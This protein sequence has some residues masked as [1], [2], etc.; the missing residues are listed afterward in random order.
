[1]DQIQNNWKRKT[2]LFLASQCITLF[3]SMIV[4]MSII[5]Y[6]TL[7]TSS[8]GWVAAFTICS[9]LP[10]FLISFFAGVWADRY[11]RK[12]LIVLADGVITIATLIMFLVMPMI[13]SDFVLL[14]ALLVISIVRSIGAGVQT[15]AV[16]AVIPHLVPAEYLMKYNG[17][18]ATIQ[19]IVQFI[20]PA[21]AG[22]VL[23]IGTFR[24]TLFIDILTALIG[25]GLLSC[26]LLPKQEV[27][28][29]NIS[30]FSEIKAGI[31]YSFSD[32]MI[33]KI[34]IVY[35]LFILL[36]VPAGFMSALLVSRVYGDVYWYL[37]AVELVGFA[38]MALGGV[39]MGMW[40]GFK[41]RVKTFAFGLLI[42]SIMTIG[43]GVSP[44][45]ILYLVMM[46]VYSIALTIIQTATTTIIQ[47]KAEGSMLGR[48]FGLMGAMYSGFLP[49]GMAIFGPLADILPLQ[50][51]MVGSGI[52][53]VL[54]TVYLQVKSKSNL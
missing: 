2:L 15:P 47:E 7:K 29:E 12:K 28:N 46:F 38:G 34:L 35:G 1:M 31:H 24:S 25:I 3:G 10:Q 27:S 42:L 22:T 19:S 13:S 44:Y 50:W 5:W 16:N 37:T 40:G 36:S 20:A 18:N 39:L 6:V 33:G 23:S 45:F 51:I 53:L 26:V 32:K 30:V 49:V 4:Q 8:G 21:V 11:N 9:Y 52:A 41:S 54:V 43:M 17:I 48:V 14:S